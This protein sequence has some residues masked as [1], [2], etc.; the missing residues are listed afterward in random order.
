VHCAQTAGH[1]SSCADLYSCGA[2]LSRYWPHCPRPALFL[3]PY[4]YPRALNLLGCTCNSSRSTSPSSI[5]LSTPTNSHFSSRRPSLFFGYIVYLGIACTFLPLPPFSP[6]S[7]ELLE[8]LGPRISAYPAAVLDDSTDLED[9][10]SC[11]AR[12]QSLSSHHG[13]RGQ[14]HL[15]DRQA[16]MEQQAGL[17]AARMGRAYCTQTYTLHLRIH[18]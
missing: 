13:F 17:E 18:N 5:L 2:A 7:R 1:A 8:Y 9:R 14:H 16:G 12:L 3:H 15:P 11:S 6:L 4:S 10:K